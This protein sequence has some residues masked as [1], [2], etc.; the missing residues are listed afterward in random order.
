MA[1][2]ADLEH[3]TVSEFVRRAVRERAE[4]V[5][6]PRPS[7]AEELRD[8]IGAFRGDGSGYSENTGAGFTEIVVEKHTR[9]R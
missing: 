4:K 6:Q 3:V 1:R 2:A 8:F 9:R 7:A 5:L